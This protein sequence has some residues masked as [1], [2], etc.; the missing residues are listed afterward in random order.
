VLRHGPARRANLAYPDNRL[1]AF[2]SFVAARKAGVV[3]FTEEGG[4]LTACL[5]RIGQGSGQGGIER[6]FCFR[7]RRE[8]DLESFGTAE[9]IIE[10]D[11]CALLRRSLSPSL[12]SQKTV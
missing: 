11:C 6:T 7:A 9:C 10:A 5:E 4:N 12:R 1:H 2:K 3:S 8:V